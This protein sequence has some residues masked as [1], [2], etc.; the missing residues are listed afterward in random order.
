MQARRSTASA[1]PARWNW[2]GKKV[3]QLTYSSA[4]KVEWRVKRGTRNKYCID[5]PHSFNSFVYYLQEKY[6]FQVDGS[7]DGT[8]QLI[9]NKTPTVG[10][11]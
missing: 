4:L 2:L 1:S 5:A 3:L 10:P 9:Q 8:R 6:G 7:D 11:G